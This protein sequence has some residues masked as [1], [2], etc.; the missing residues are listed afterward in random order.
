MIGERSGTLYGL[1]NTIRVKLME[2]APVTGGLRFE[3]A[4]GGEPARHPRPGRP[5]A[6]KPKHRFKPKRR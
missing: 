4:E 1:G 5:G 6:P 3:L 2:A